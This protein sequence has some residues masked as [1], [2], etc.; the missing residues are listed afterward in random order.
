MSQRTVTGASA[1]ALRHQFLAPCFDLQGFIFGSLKSFTSM[2]TLRNPRHQEQQR[3]ETTGRV[4]TTF[5]H[6]AFFQSLLFILNS[7]RK[8]NLLCI[9]L[10]PNAEE[11]ENRTKGSRSRKRNENKRL[12]LLVIILQRN[13]SNEHVS[14]TCSA[15]SR[16][17]LFFFFPANELKNQRRLQHH[18][19]SP[20]RYSGVFHVSCDFFLL[21]LGFTGNS[22]SVLGR[23]VWA[24]L[25]HLPRRK[26][27]VQ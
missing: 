11:P 10:L 19:L 1:T 12:S 17:T 7:Y 14:K 24:R 27:E 26:G 9:R 22:R 25:Q 4:R 3:E 16:P 2:T 21:E 15:S 13:D 8:P 20:V 6:L 18:R 5:P 23:L